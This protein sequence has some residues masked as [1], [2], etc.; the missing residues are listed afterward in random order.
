M[1]KWKIS[2][3]GV[4][5]VVTNVND[6]ALLLSEDI[7]ALPLAAQEAAVATG[8]SPVVADALLGFFDHYGTT[9]ESISNRIQN[10]INGVNGAT[11]AYIDGDTEIAAAI[12]AEAAAAGGDELW[13][14]EDS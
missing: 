14:P 6:H 10:S 7:D 9:L 5:T 8:D 3:S 2:P 12:Q 11:Q 13:D 4:T 1:A